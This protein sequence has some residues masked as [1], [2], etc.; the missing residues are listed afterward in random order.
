MNDEDILAHFGKRQQFKRNFGLVSILG[1][2][3]TLML[4]WQGS[5][6]NLLPPLINGGPTGAIIAF[7]LVIFGVLCQVLVMAEMASM[8]P[9][10]GGEYN[11]VAV[12]APQNLSNFLSY[13]VGWVTV[14]AWQA[15]CASVAWINTLLIVA[16]ASINWPTYSMQMWHA[17]LVF[18]AVILLS[19]FV[20]TYL[21]RAFPSI[22]AMVLILHIV[23]FFA[24]LIVLVYLAPKNSSEMVFNTFFNGGGFSSTAQS[25]LIGS[26]TIMYS[27]NGVDG[28][29]HMAEEIENSAVVIPRAMI[30]S[31]FINGVTGY[32]MLIALCFCMG[33]L[34]ELLSGAFPFPF[35]IILLKITG[36]TAATTVLA[37]I[38]IVTGISGSIGLMAT[39]SR[40][41]W[42]FAREDGVPLSRYV[43]R[44]E[45]HT[46]LPLYSI[47][48]TALISILLSLIALGSTTAFSA[49][50]GLTVAGFYSAFMVSACVMLWRRLVTPADQIAWGPF[51]LGRFG[52]PITVLALVYSFIG[53]FFSFWP[54]V[55]EVE[56]KTFN[57]ST[58][59]YFGVMGLSMVYYAVR[60]RKTYTGPKMEIVEVVR[61][62]RRG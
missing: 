22:E 14:I 50:T 16:V 26:V 9:L 52:V 47:G 11:W 42:A 61:G 20:N 29:T 2:A 1:L 35:M 51:R 39:A 53:W 54:P 24:I 19:V 27:F 43:S 49:L 7:P 40:M 45:R 6:A 10:A 13:T 60:A 3:C 48:I 34:D 33:P 58:V 28:A 31:V 4:T 44:I 30:L 32:A 59:V 5:I 62:D 17:V 21:G 57:W 23:G 38:I 36:S 8:I 18:W 12:L 55:A 15:A 56:V 46:A 37:S 25:A 41:L